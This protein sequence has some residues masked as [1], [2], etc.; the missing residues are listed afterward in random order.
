MDKIVSSIEKMREFK[1]Q[2]ITV[3]SLISNSARNLERLELEEK[4]KKSI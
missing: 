3:G 1:P 4:K 2:N